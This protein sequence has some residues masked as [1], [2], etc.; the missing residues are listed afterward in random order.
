[1]P[2]PA[3]SRP[4]SVAV[5][6]Q[7]LYL[8]NMG[9]TPTGPV[10]PNI[11]RF[12]L[13]GTWTSRTVGTAFG[14]PVALAPD[15]GAGRMYV[16][17]NAGFQVYDL[18]TDTISKVQPMGPF[19]RGLAVDATGRVH[20]GDAVD[21]QL[22][23]LVPMVASD[24][25]GEHWTVDA[26]QLGAPVT[27]VRPVPGDDPRARY[28]V[29]EHAAIFA[30]T[31]HGTVTVSRP[32]TAA[33]EQLSVKT[34]ALLGPA[35]EPSG[36]TG[37]VPPRDAVRPGWHQPGGRRL[38]GPDGDRRL[39]RPARHPPRPAGG[40]RVHAAR[41]RPPATVP[42]RRDLLAG[43]PRRAR[44]LGPDLRR[45][46]AD[47]RNRSVRLPDGR[48]HLEGVRPGRG[49]RLLGP[50]GVRAHRHALPELGRAGLDPP[51]RHPPRPRAAR[52]A[53]RPARLSGGHRG[54]TPAGGTY[55]DF[56]NGV[57]VWHPDGSS[58]CRLPQLQLGPDAHRLLPDHRQRRLP[59]RRAGPVRTG[60]AGAG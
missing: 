21:G 36:T 28:Q 11:T 40:E 53:V 42:A 56:Q 29:F 26:A 48:R 58:V 22:R 46:G 4:W 24:P 6:G 52:R 27:G 10:P 31:D 54:G 8:A 1:M 51:D 15:P 50:W 23:T 14:G 19:P 25:I 57:A 5:A 32:L 30:S 12:E 7:R 34:R 47:R 45:L 59:R 16:G 39:P 60:R 17:T 13:D 43:R 55:M 41:R 38:R 44:R 49:H 35:V 2:V 3:G 9:N 33:W 37:P 20:V 18:A